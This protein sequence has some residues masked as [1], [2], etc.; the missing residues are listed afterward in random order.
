MQTIFINVVAGNVGLAILKYLN[1]GIYQIQILE[2]ITTITKNKT[3][4]YNNNVTFVKFDF[5]NTETYKPAL[6][7]C[8]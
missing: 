6:E 7:S 5:M 2:S 1:F 3:K 4:F 8:G